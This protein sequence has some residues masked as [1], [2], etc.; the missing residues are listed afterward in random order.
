MDAGTG[1]RSA[2]GHHASM[3]VAVMVNANGPFVAATTMNTP[4]CA[5]RI[6]P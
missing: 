6:P 5:G 1:A 4:C 3:T 2:P